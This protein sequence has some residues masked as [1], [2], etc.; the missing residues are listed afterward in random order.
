MRGLGSD[1]V[2]HGEWTPKQTDTRTDGHRDSMTDP[3][4][5]VKSGKII[6][7]LVL[8]LLLTHHQRINDFLCV[9]FLLLNN[10]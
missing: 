6:I 10:W 3:A 8:V 9:V 2:T 4:Q 1:H 5:M 7:F